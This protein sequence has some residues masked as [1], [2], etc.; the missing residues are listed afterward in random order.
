MNQVVRRE[1]D[2]MRRPVRRMPRNVSRWNE[3]APFTS[4]VVPW[5]PAGWMDTWADTFM[6]EPFLLESSNA[7]N[8][9]PSMGGSMNVGHTTTTTTEDG[10][11]LVKTK[12][13]AGIQQEDIHL[14][15]EAGGLKLSAA[16]T[17]EEERK[18]RSGKGSSKHTTHVSVAHFW[19]LPENVK[20]EDIEAHWNAEEGILEIAMPQAKSLER[21][22]TPIVIGGPSKPH[23]MLDASKS[24]SDIMEERQSGEAAKDVTKNFEKDAS[25]AETGA[26]TPSSTFESPSEYSPSPKRPTKGR[27]TEEINLAQHQ[28][29]SMD[30]M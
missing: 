15:F 27:T 1:L 21:K 24:A 26:T 28:V 25:S 18:I 9:W 4:S 19:P 12:M 3:E 30:E 14:D 10:N 23:Q 29:P 2:S 11:M 13:P 16:K 5:G 22:S 7:L 8:A 6:E 20:A 17:H